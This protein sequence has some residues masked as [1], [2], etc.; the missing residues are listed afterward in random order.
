[1]DELT[2]LESDAFATRCGG[3]EL[4]VNGE[5]GRDW[6]EIIGVGLTDEGWIGK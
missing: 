1:M 5:T 3:A 2:L 6:S 4:V